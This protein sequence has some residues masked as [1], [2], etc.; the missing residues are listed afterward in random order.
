MSTNYINCSKSPCAQRN[1]LSPHRP[2]ES[3]HCHHPNGLG[4]F[5]RDL[6]VPALSCRADPGSASI[7]MSWQYLPVLR[8]FIV[9]TTLMI[10]IYFKT[11]PVSGTLL[12]I[13]HALSHLVL[14]ATLCG[15]YQSPCCINS[16]KFPSL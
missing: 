16:V 14:R 10:T 13:P 2:C 15:T 6:E 11:L 4:T 9:M 1:K 5:T 12:C 3:Y 8:R 7:P